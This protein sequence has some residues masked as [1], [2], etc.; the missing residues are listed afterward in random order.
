MEKNSRKESL[1]HVSL[2]ALA[3]AALSC[4]VSLMV[5]F[6]GG[7]KAGSDLQ[8]LIWMQAAMTPVAIAV[9]AANLF[10]FIAGDG[11]AKGLQRL[12]SAIPQWLVFVFFFLNLLFAAGEIAFLI[13]T[14]AAGQAIHWSNHIPL[15]CMLSSSL[16]F[17]TLYARAHTYPGSKPAMSGRWP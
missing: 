14:R 3:L 11:F 9:I 15:V 2:I 5:V 10:S 13:A 4:L 1:I 8:G 6:V 17:L 16:A 12:W 7:G